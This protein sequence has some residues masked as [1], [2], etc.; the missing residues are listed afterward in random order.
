[1]ATARTPAVTAELEPMTS[2]TPAATATVRGT[3]SRPESFSKA[4]RVRRR[5]E[6][7]RV[8]NRGVRVQSRFFTL[9]VMPGA[10]PTSRLGLVASRKL[11]GAVERNRAKRLIRELFRRTV[12]GA[13]E[14]ALD[15]VVI[16]RRD[17][18]EASFATLSEDFASLWRRGSGRVAA[19]ARPSRP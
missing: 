6:F 4:R 11:G 13:G 14:P 2:R 10:T 7:Q 15:A 17:L 8:F 12:K 16:P 9:L 18:F 3:S 1:V 19:S 5:G